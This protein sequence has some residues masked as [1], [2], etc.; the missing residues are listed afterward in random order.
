MQ[1]ATFS[2]V[3][4]YIYGSLTSNTYLLTGHTSGINLLI[5][6]IKKGIRNGLPLINLVRTIASCLFATC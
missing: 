5:Y 1:L 3:A 2:E 6:L 4:D